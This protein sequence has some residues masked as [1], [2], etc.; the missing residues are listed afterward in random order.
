VAEGLGDAVSPGLRR[1]DLPALKL[2]P[3]VGRETWRADIWLVR[4]PDGPV[5]VKDYAERGFFLRH[6]IGPF[7]VNR[8]I[9]AYRRL[10]GIRGIPR[11]L[12][13]V[14]RHAFV[15][16]FVDGRTFSARERGR[17]DGAFFSQ[18]EETVRGMHARGIVHCDLRQRT[19]VLITPQEEPVILDFA[20]SARLGRGRWSQRFLVPLLS[21]VDRGGI[22]KMKIRVAPSTLTLQERRS[23]RILR[24]LGRLWLPSSLRR[25]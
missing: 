24:W 5:V 16:E 18:M 14:D 15:L 1:E 23:A 20:A 13:R 19:N 11:F 17:L 4:G 22:L 7:L 8:E 21:W 2:R 6:V 9:Q 25:L 3:L 12:G 10:E